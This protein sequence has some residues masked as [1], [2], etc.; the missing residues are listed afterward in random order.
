MK[1]IVRYLLKSAGSETFE[2]VLDD[3]PEEIQ[4]S[5]HKDLYRELKWIKIKDTYIKIDQISHMEVRVI[6]L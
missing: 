4:D 2:I 6:E 1:I 3:P 5:I